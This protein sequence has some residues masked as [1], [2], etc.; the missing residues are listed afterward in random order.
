MGRPRLRWLL[1]T[2]A[3]A[4]AAGLLAFLFLPRPISVDT[5]KVVV[6]P[7]AEAVQDQGST[8]VREAFVVAAP[9]RAN[10]T[11]STS[12]SAIAWWRARR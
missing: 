7:I 12:T 10:S 2:A 1:I 3:A 8:R 6:G 11:A 9:C 5:A 4:L